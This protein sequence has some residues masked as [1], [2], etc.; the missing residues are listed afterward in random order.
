MHWISNSL[1]F[2]NE[3]GFTALPAGCRWN[4]EYT[5]IGQIGFWWNSLSNNEFGYG[6]HMIRSSEDKMIWFNYSNSYG[7]SVRCIKEK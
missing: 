2:N 7:F 6:G 5:E 1:A 3:Y 4:G